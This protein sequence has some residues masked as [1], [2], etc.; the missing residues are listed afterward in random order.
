[1][2][3]LICICLK[4]LGDLYMPTTQKRTSSIDRWWALTFWNEYLYFVIW[5][6]HHFHSSLIC[7]VIILPCAEFKT[8]TFYSHWQ[9]IDPGRIMN[10][11]HGFINEHLLLLLI[12]V[13]IAL[14]CQAKKKFK[15]L[16]HHNRFNNVYRVPCGG[17]ELQTD[18][19]SLNIF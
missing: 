19:W 10:L 3:L 12:T 8:A 17:R 1:M 16:D 4:E 15:L 11:I 6:D 13:V 9:N 14:G 5:S 2:P 18:F 7:C